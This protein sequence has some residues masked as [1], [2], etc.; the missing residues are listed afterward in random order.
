MGQAWIAGKP[1]TLDAAIAAA[2]KLLHASHCPLIA[3]LGTDIAGARAAI[4]LAERTGAV[5]DHMNSEA[6]LRDLDVMRSSGVML[7][8][9]NEAHARA[10]TLLLTGSGL[11]EAWPQLQQGLL[12]PIRHASGIIGGERRIYWLCPGRDA[13]VLEGTA[14]TALG[15][16]P[17]G[18]PALLAA[19]RA[20]SAG[21]PIGNSRIR[22]K[23]LNAA[24]TALKAARFGVAVWSA[25][26]LDSLAIEMLCGLVSD[27]NATTRFSGL[28]LAAGNNA[29]GVLHA[30]GWTAG[31][32]VRTSFARG[33]AEHDTWLFDGRRLVEHG[34]S[35]CIVW[36]SAYGAQSPEW[37]DA[38]LAIAL[39]DRQSRVRS[40]PHV[41]IEVGR[42]GIDHAAVEYA[43]SF[44]ALA[45]SAATSAT[46]TISVADVIT[47]IASNLSGGRAC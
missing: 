14:V 20:C 37:H 19:L 33:F 44:G 12:G 10:D 9:P 30:C 45:A 31:L 11:V 27:L 34:E 28:P 26:A 24:S 25:A 15:R 38:P 6:V 41:H 47:R 43:S 46:E 3:G 16:D 5:I 40:T 18:L 36:I 29:M 22:P 1:A 21:R 4:S 2:A 17:N 42:P 13:A 23:V 35:D 7:T 39:T 32:P 8:T